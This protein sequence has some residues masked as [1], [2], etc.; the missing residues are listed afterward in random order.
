M[1]DMVSS[2][3]IESVVACF[4]RGNGTPGDRVWPS[5][6]SFRL[7]LPGAECSLMDPSLLSF[8]KCR[9]SVEGWSDGERVS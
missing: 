9:P 4:V 8:V 7:M 5:S 3:L 1:L 2:E 6:S